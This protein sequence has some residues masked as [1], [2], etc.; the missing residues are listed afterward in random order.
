L[1]GYWGLIISGI[2][3]LVAGFVGIHLPDFREEIAVS[4]GPQQYKA[5]SPRAKIV[6]LCIGAIL[7]V[8]GAIRLV[9]R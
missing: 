4:S 6:Y 2:F 9:Y 1:N 8:V 3:F 5:L 7:V